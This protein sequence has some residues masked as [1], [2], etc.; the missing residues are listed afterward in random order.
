MPFHLTSAQAFDICHVDVHVMCMFI[1]ST[2]TWS[3]CRGMWDHGN[4]AG[5]TRG[6]SYRIAIS[7]DVWGVRC[8]GLMECLPIIHNC[9]A[10]H[11]R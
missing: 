10:K 2:R 9:T 5:S 7:T 6:T 8:I 4:V 1:R 11:R 3:A